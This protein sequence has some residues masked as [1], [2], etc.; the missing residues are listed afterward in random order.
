VRDT[1]IHDAS[2][3][4]GATGAIDLGL[5]YPAAGDADAALGPALTRL[6]KR[7]DGWLALAPYA[8][9][10]AHR[11]AGARWLRTV[12]LSANEGDVLVC[13]GVQHGLAA[14]LA[15]LTAPG[16]AVLTESLTGPGLKAVAAT[17]NLRLVGVACDDEGLLPDA[18]V[19]ACQATEA[20]VLYTMPTLHTPTT[21]TMPD[22]RRRAIAE[23]V[24]ARELIAIEDDAWGFLAGG[25]VTPLRNFAPDRV[26]YLT[27]FSKCL[28]PGLRVGYAVVPEALQR[29]IISSIGAIAWVAPLMAE[30]ATRWIDDGTAAAIAQQRVRTARERQRIAERV[31]GP[32]LARSALP[33]F[34]HWLAL[35]EPWRVD[36][37]VAQAATQGVS[38]AATDIFMPGR[39]ATPYAIRVCTGTEPDVSRLEQGLRILARMLR[40]GRMGYSLPG[41]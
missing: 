25:R 39:A 13:A 16:D 26:V 8:G 37:L 21:T 6:A 9:I 2:L 24:R 22:R 1:G 5:N 30:L 3:A 15:A 23:V 29:A 17:R 38:L 33:T 40:A 14:T 10:A 31:L 27:T 28:A 7:R 12:G 36:E 19:S 41:A 34:H 4:R 35:A 20:R 18:L 11:A 32:G